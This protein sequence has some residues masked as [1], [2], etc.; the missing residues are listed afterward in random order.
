MSKRVERVATSLWAAT[1]IV[2]AV[3]IVPPAFCYLL[4]L[5]GSS[6]GPAPDHWVQSQFPITWTLNPTT[7]SNISGSQTVATVITDSFATWTSAP[8]VALSV[9]RTADTTSTSVGANGTN[10]VCFV[11]TGDFSKEAQT[12]AITLITTVDAGQPNLHGGTAVVNGQLVDADILFNP[13]VSFSTGGGSNQDLQTVATH[14]IGHFLGLDHSAVVRAMMFPFAPA[15]EHTLG[16]DDVAG[17]ALLYPKATPDVPTGTISGAVTLAGNG[18]FGAH[19]YADSMTSAM[20]YPASIRKTPI[21][22]LTTPGGGYQIQNIPPDSYV[23]TAEPLDLPVQEADVSGYSQV[24]GQPA[25]QTDFTT[26]WH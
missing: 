8:N 14:E 25:V 24:F 21:G 22:T 20:P 13:A 7:D 16:Y 9:T 26:R 18:V 1:V 2:L 17:L 23:V 3:L 6:S 19:V 10:L 12:L 5:T 4:E 11:C 15:L